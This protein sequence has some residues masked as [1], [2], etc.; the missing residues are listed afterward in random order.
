MRRV[1]KTLGATQL[2][3]TVYECLRPGDLPV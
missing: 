2:G 1:G 3:T